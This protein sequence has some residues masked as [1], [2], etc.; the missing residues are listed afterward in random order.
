[1]SRYLSRFNISHFVLTVAT[2][3]VSLGAFAA[4]PD[5]ERQ[6]GVA[7]KAVSVGSDTMANM[8]EFWAEQFEVLYPQASIEVDA[9]GSS[10]APPA[11]A[12]GAATLGAMS[13]AMKP[14][15]IRAFER[16]YGYPPTVLRVALDAIAIFVERQN[17][18]PGLTL[19]Q[20]DAIFSSTR[21]CGS[22]Y[23]ITA[24]KQL[25]IEKSNGHNNI[26]LYGRNSVSGTYGSF[27]VAALCNGDFKNTVNEQP[28]SASVVLSVASSHGAMG[29]AAVGYK[30]AGVRALPI[31]ETKDKLVSLTVENVRSERY[32]FSRYVYLIVN[33]PPG[34]EMP[35][36]E[37]EFLRF[38]L[39]R[40]GQ[41]MVTRDGCFPIPDVMVTR[42][43]RLIND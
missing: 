9:T 23:N 42:Q 29:Y 17:T 7:G 35:T 27:K 39:S 5:Y 14:S 41:D 34:E 31:G 38:V 13:R 1:M 10:T 11:L 32:P 33:K 18:L 26:R 30:T 12:E 20:V 21:F 8:M 19:E 40:Q 16:K 2:L 36:L 6:P 24:W 28:G 15:E 22:K 37:R 3:C 25:G 43:L 4:P